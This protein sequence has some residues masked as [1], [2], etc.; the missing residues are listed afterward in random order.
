MHQIIPFCYWNCN[1]Y[2]V[3]FLK[4]ISTKQ[5][6]SYLPSYCQQWYRIHMRSHNSR[7]QISCTRAGSCKTNSHFSRN[8]RISVCRMYCSLLMSCKVMFNLVKAVNF[9]INRYYRSTRIPKHISHTYFMQTLQQHSCTIYHFATHFSTTFSFKIL[10]Y[11]ILFP[12]NL[13]FLL[14]ILFY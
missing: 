14:H 5:V 3:S 8:S 9:I 11:I 13:T 2:N 4:S 12:E 7:N 1:S 10:F 6:A